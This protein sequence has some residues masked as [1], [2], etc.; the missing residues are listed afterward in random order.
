MQTVT[1]P[2]G[3]IKLIRVLKVEFVRGTRIIVA[4]EL[5]GPDEPKSAHIIVGDGGAPAKEEEVGEM[6]FCAG[7][8][9]G[10]Y[11]RY[12]GERIPF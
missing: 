9:F 12:D 8:P 11:W 5:N 6:T 7:G 10:G 1:W 2:F 4:E 3:T